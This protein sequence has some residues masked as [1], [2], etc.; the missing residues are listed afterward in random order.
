MLGVL[1]TII[2]ASSSSSSDDDVASKLVSFVI[3]C[4]INNVSLF[5]MLFIY[6]FYTIQKRLCEYKCQ[7]LVQ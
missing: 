7:N 3:I 2:V 6:I 4:R 1:I 5:F